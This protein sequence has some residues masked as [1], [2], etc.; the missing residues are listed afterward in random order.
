MRLFGT[1]GIRA[2]VNNHPMTPETVLKIGMAAAHILKEKHGRNMILIGKD[3]R[4]SG[5]MIESALTSGICS[6]GMN[7]TLVGPLP[8]PGIAFLTRTLRLDA[9]IVISASHNPFEDNGIKFFSS[10]GFKLPDEVEKK[11]EELVLDDGLSKNRPKG[12]NIGK[13][14]RLDDATG[15]YIEYIKSTI[16]KGIT[17][18]GIKIVVDCANGAAYKTTPWLLRELGADVI[19]INDRPDG[20]NI[21]AG[22]GSLHAEGLQKAVKLHKA[23]IGIAHDGDADRTIFCD[24]KGR[25]VDGDKVM[26]M[27]AVEMKKKQTL[28]KDTVVSTVMSNLGLEK[29]LE[30]NNIKLIRTKVGDRYVVERMLDGGYNLGGEQSGHIVF[31]DHNTTGDGPLTAVHVLYLMKINDSA[32]SKLVSGIKLYP[33]IL[34]N[35]EIEHKHDIKTIPEI[36]NTIKAA[37]K[38]L[39]GR[40]RILVRP[41]GTEPKIRIM[42]EGGD[43]KL[44]TKLSKDISRVIKE[45]M[46]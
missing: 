16:P 19:S 40:G 18:D 1:D 45:K 29:Y 4:L 36:E 30:M 32:L 20:I 9:G 37:E 34:T 42:I 15:R 25:M 2:T 22:C 7:V 13:A 23:D 17:F 26:A 46:I 41:S 24:E 21:N 35:V 11:I 33:Q 38:K 5:Y 27:C 12:S 44:I 43:L 28:K 3:T 31:L 6:M 8:T 14:F 10:E 39:A